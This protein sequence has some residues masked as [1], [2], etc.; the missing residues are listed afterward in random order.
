MTA[1]ESASLSIPTT[2]VAA[3]FESDDELEG[4]K[5]SFNPMGESQ[6]FRKVANA[7]KRALK[8]IPVGFGKPSK[9][10][11]KRLHKN[12]KKRLKAEQAAKSAEVARIEEAARAAETAQIA[13][14][15]EATRVAAA[16]ETSKVNEA[17]A[18]A[19]IAA[20]A[21]ELVAEA[22]A[23]AE[24]P[25]IIATIV[26]IQAADE[27][28]INQVD[29][30]E[31][32]A[33]PK[34][35]NQEPSIEVIQ[36]TDEVE[37][38]QV[39]SIEVVVTHKV[40]EQEPSIVQIARADE[41][42]ENQTDG[43]EDRAAHVQSCETVVKTERDCPTFDVGKNLVNPVA[44]NGTAG[45]EC[46]KSWI[47]DFAFEFR[48]FAVLAIAMAF[49]TDR[50]C[51]NKNN[52]QS[53]SLAP[54]ARGAPP[55]LRTD[56]YRPRP[57]AGPAPPLRPRPPLPRRHK[58]RHESRRL[59]SAAGSSKNV[60]MNRTGASTT[61]RVLGTGRI[62]SANVTQLKLRAPN[63]SDVRPSPSAICRPQFGTSILDVIPRS[64][65]YRVGALW[66]L[67]QRGIRPLNETGCRL[68]AKPSFGLPMRVNLRRGTL[69]MR[70]SRWTVPMT[71]NASAS[72]SIS[73]KLGCVDVATPNSSVVHMPYTL[74][75]GFRRRRTLRHDQNSSKYLRGIHF[76]NTSSMSASFS[77]DVDI[78]AVVLSFRPTPAH[79]SAISNTSQQPCAAKQICQHGTAVPCRKV[80]QIFE[81]AATIPSGL[82][83]SLDLQSA[84]RPIVVTAASTEGCEPPHNG[85]PGH[86]WADRAYQLKL[87]RMTRQAAFDVVMSQ[88]PHGREA[89]YQELHRRGHIRGATTTSFGRETEAPKAG[90][91]RGRHLSSTQLLSTFQHV[92]N[93][94]VSPARYLPHRSMS[95][96]TEVAVV[97]NANFSVL[98]T[99]YT[100][101][102][103]VRQH[104][105]QRRFM[106]RPS[107][108]SVRWLVPSAGYT[109]ATVQSST[110]LPCF[111]TAATDTSGLPSAVYNGSMLQGGFQTVRSTRDFWWHQRH[112]RRLKLGSV[113]ASVAV[114]TSKRTQSVCGSAVVVAPTSNQTMDFPMHQFELADRWQRHWRRG[115]QLGRPSMCISTGFS[116]DPQSI[117]PSNGS[118]N[119]LVTPC[120][121]AL[122][123]AAYISDAL[124]QNNFTLV[125]SMIKMVP[126]SSSP[127]LYSQKKSTALTVR[128][129]PHKVTKRPR[130][131]LNLVVTHSV[132]SCAKPSQ[133]WFDLSVLRGAANPHKLQRP[134]PS[135]D[136]SLNLHSS[137][138]GTELVE[139]QDANSFFHRILATVR[140]R[141]STDSTRLSLTSVLPLSLLASNK[142]HR[143]LFKNNNTATPAQSD[144]AVFLPKTMVEEKTEKGIR[145][146]WSKRGWGRQS[147]ALTVRPTRSAETEIEA[148]V[149]ENCRDGS[150]R[151]ISTSSLVVFRLDNGPITALAH[152]I[153]PIERPILG[154]VQPT[155]LL[156]WVSTAREVAKNR[157][158][159][160]KQS[161]SRTATRDAWPMAS[162]NAENDSHSGSRQLKLEAPLTPLENV[163]ASPEEQ[164]VVEWKKVPALLEYVDWNEFAGIGALIKHSASTAVCLDSAL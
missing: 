101:Q 59:T 124:T 51:S 71:L 49:S 43:G 80:N 130:R 85:T 32:T 146:K 97:P 154:W 28:E 7:S 148:S 77:V 140:D 15:V 126:C 74:Q 52:D 122:L 57:Q 108:S 17:S 94:T 113:N 119:M 58:Q 53:G 115:R 118:A 136:C 65:S 66:P 104:R 23:A 35:N 111:D 41:A 141:A 116:V 10:Q 103:L 145:R 14:A 139:H 109:S 105:R 26:A 72:P 61:A 63:Y 40:N 34:V 39:D 162:P 158:R 99:P 100:T 24:T 164:L 11:L 87:S 147:T 95:G 60:R 82:K 69:T 86:Y 50:Q 102:A 129:H 81:A 12:E 163:T 107:T 68:P 38:S 132:H 13:E 54:E 73:A 98:V 128:T 117:W 45:S 20:E 149:V 93:S 36:P 142:L 127:F 56:L 16:A 8:A 92:F 160:S 75:A 78:G 96:C 137:E 123:P 30:I 67:P 135:A 2:P 64:S 5:R 159:P 134:S 88:P 1:T 22:T 29:S 157:P 33:T 91:A 4:F 27:A 48:F 151:S 25:K 47:S 150:R 19:R 70:S 37:I 76:V 42:D 143:D 114:E 110:G 79:R 44:P 3:G 62:C 138:A 125:A 112:L 152:K 161:A 46:P 9:S 18:A 6:I 55:Q 120:L 89:K 121:P 31:V 156:T 84:R 21:A 131:S 153:M 155:G 144:P 83:Q 90:A 133:H 106:L